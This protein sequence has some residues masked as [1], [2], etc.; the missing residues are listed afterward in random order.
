V[1]EIFDFEP[2]LTEITERVWGSLVE[3]PLLPRQ[4]GQPAP[5]PGSRTFTGCVQ[6]TGAWEGAVTVHCSERLARLLT[7]AMFMVDPDDTSAEEVTDALGELANMVGGNVKALLPE[8]CRISLPAVADGMDYRL[9]VPG[10]RPVSAVTW[11]C[12]G[13]PLMVR[14][15]ERR[16]PETTAGAAASAATTGAEA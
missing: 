15:L 4:P 5:A 13:E 10:A 11:T 16:I 3:S 9:S 8:P 6:I 1:N 14:L 7:A 2:E 12:G